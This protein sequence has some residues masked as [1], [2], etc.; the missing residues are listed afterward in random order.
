[1]CDIEVD[2]SLKRLP[3]TQIR[4]ARS[5]LPKDEDD[6]G[7][8]TASA[9]GPTDAF[10][11]PPGG[12]AGGVQ[13]IS[14][15]KAGD[16]IGTLVTFV[17]AEAIAAYL[18]LLPFMDPSDDGFTGRWFLTLGVGVLSVIYAVGY[19]KIAAVQAGGEF[20]M[21]WIPIF[22]T[23]FAF[24][25]WVFAIPESPFGEFSFYSPELGGAAGVVAATLISFV[26]AVTGETLTVKA[27]EEGAA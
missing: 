18:I 22:T 5:A 21:P 8:F 6:S 12:T 9:T 24:T 20:S 14:A 10:A 2:R 4:A 7:G 26:G 17:P 11:P 25:F 27:A 13:A 1:M 16:V 23:L 3:A 19:R 15:T